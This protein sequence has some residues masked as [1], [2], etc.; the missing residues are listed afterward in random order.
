MSLYRVSPADLEQFTVVTNPFRTFTS[1]STEGVTGSVNVYARRSS[2]EKD[3]GGSSA[4]LDA[5]RDD[6]DVSSVLR[7]IQFAAK[8][9]R[10]AVSSSLTASL[11][12]M[13]SSY[14]D[15]ITSLSTS[16]RKQTTMK[17]SRITPGVTFSENTLRKSVI[18]D[19]LNPY[20]RTIYPSAHY[21]YTNYNALNFFT[22]STVP[23]DSAVLYPNVQGPFTHTGY[24]S[25]T[26]SLSGAFSFDFY[27]NPRYQAGEG[28]PFK[29]GTIFHLPGCYALSVVT[30]SLK[31]ANGKPAAWRLQ[32]QL[33]QS[34]NVP[35]SL[36]VASTT[37]NSA[38]VKP[39]YWASGSAVFLSDDN[40][41][42][43]NNWHHVVVRWGT[44]LVNNG[45]GS[46]NV[47]GIDR[48]LFAYAGT[49]IVP[50]IPLPSG[51]SGP[52]ALVVGNY[53]SGSNAGL[54]SIA[55]F[56]AADTAL[57]DG[58]TQII[59]STGVDEPT[60]F[61]FDH[62][63]NAELHE[64]AI[65][66]YYM[67]DTEIISSSS[68]GLQYVDRDRVAFYVP[69]FFIEASPTRRFVGTFGGILQ[70][71][72]FEIDGTTVDPFNVAMAFGVGG[73]YIN[74]ENF[75]YDF[76][77]ST[78][79]R[80]HLMSA[81][82]ISSTTA[83][84]RANEFL[85]T[86]KGVVRRNTFI[87]PCDDGNFVPSYALLSSQSMRYTAVDDMNVPEP[88]FINLDDMVSTASLLFG[89]DFAGDSTFPDNIIGGTAEQPGISPGSAMSAYKKVIDRSIAAGNFTP[90][91]QDG[92][93]LDIYE[94]TRDPS[95][96]QI[97]IFNIS[98]LYYGKRIMPGT[99]ALADSMFTAS[100]G[101]L[102]F[103]LKDDGFGNLYRADCFTSQSKWN[104]VGNIYYDEGVALV[105]SPHLNFFG[106]QA[107]SVSFRGTQN[108][109]VMKVNVLAPANALNSSSN[110]SYVSLPPSPFPN[111]P[112]TTFVYVSNINLHDSDFNVVAK[113]QLAQPILKRAGDR[114]AFRIKLDW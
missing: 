11:G 93:P 37:S 7:S 44:S 24:V 8:A 47:D 90:G 62:P 103:T 88:S 39:A 60:S 26:Y 36:V 82:V 46:F 65:K 94:R 49:T 1:S 89:T 5:A 17:I 29:A 13:L 78:Y 99:F 86:Q 101:A 98:N 33:S 55:Y 34:A 51:L 112:D 72:F 76:A 70:T 95:S 91:V 58:L 9:T 42:K 97:T 85:Y 18:K 57:R 30:G 12:P 14:M 40:V 92:Q 3:M 64:L 4:F 6:S 16:V 69:P 68:T 52:D 96:D 22:S 105:K 43:W 50:K 45:T 54:N 66:R 100:G 106:K 107:F 25:G 19:L 114:I 81:S 102:H 53:F 41:L 48:G 83:L 21:A 31:D 80:L 63:L 110:P 111:D 20:Y 15:T 67:S 84:S 77:N 113:A 79:P 71:P 28:F 59:G 73:H 61:T 10:N 56:F 27:I 35:P 75:T 104:S 109:H 108:I 2:I 74:I 38:S 23:S 87:V 32:L